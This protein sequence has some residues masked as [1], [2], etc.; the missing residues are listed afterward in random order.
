MKI[1]LQNGAQISFQGTPS[2]QDIQEAIQHANSGKPQPSQSSMLGNVGSALDTWATGAGNQVLGDAKSI[3]GDVSQ[4]VNNP[5]PASIGQGALNV[6][7]DAAGILAAPVG[8][9]VNQGIIQPTAD[10]LSS[11]QTFQKIATGAAGDKVTQLQNMVS[12]L[13][14]KHPNIAHDLNSVYNL[15]ATFAG[16]EGAKVAGEGLDS[17][18]SSI[19]DTLKGGGEETPPPGNP[20]AGA[21]Q[22]QPPATPGAAPSPSFIDNIK[23][24]LSSIPKNVEEALKNQTDGGKYFQKVMQ[25]SSDAMASTRNSNPMQIWGDEV[26]TPALKATKVLMD[27]SMSV[28]NAVAEKFGDSSVDSSK[29]SGVVDSFK[30]DI[31]SK[32]GALVKTGEDGLTDFENSE[33]RRIR[34]GKADLNTIK[35][36]YKEITGLQKGKPTFNSLNDTISNLDDIVFKKA[37][38]TDIPVN[39]QTMGVIKSAL[40]SLRDMRDS[41]AGEMGADGDKYLQSNKM[42]SDIKGAY[43]K[44]NEGLGN[45]AEKGA[46]FMKK[47]FA[48]SDSKITPALEEIEKLTGMNIVDKATLVKW[49]MENSGDTRQASLIDQVVKGVDTTK[50]ALGMLGD[51]KSGNFGKAI[52]TG[53]GK[54]V[55]ALEDK[56]GKAQRI[57]EANGKIKS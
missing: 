18:A 40:G 32:L 43:D 4:A 39:S 22:V 19:A 10:A 33:G 55:G 21:T 49:V 44:V 12:G 56:F 5:T 15:V 41:I 34:V 25:D 29:I 3:G 20:P 6:A 45:N 48:P 8:Q 23:D 54:A 38:R 31:S 11:N 35:N 52:S 27:K 36:V 30:K 57:I 47:I 9:A 24:K 16:V 1:T 14:Q 37:S 51:I 7:G 26:V 53:A 2:Q 46:A 13:A 42:F 28:R 17:A 50:E